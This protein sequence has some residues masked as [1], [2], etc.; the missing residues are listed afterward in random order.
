MMLNEAHRSRIGCSSFATPAAVVPP[1]VGSCL[2][3]GAA[4]Q[5]AT[6]CGENLHFLAG[7]GE[8]IARQQPQ[9]QSH[10][11][12]QHQQSPEFSG[13]PD[14]NPRRDICDNA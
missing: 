11:A 13:L 14:Q 3:S 2:R 12:F 6:D 5:F 7:V 1:T 10:Q 8:A 9:P 4:W